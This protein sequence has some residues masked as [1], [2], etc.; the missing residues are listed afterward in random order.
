M[1]YQFRIQFSL[2]DLKSPLQTATI[3]SK[4]YLS[5]EKIKSSLAGDY[6]I[7]PHEVEIHSVLQSIALR[8]QPIRQRSYSHH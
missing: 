7:E 1:I 3:L 6:E 8:K 2:F 4:N 5:P